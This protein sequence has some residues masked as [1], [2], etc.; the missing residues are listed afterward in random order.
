MWATVPIYISLVLL[1]FMPPVRLPI[2][3]NAPQTFMQSL[4][5]KVFSY[6]ICLSGSEYIHPSLY[7]CIY[8]YLLVSTCK[9]VVLFNSFIFMYLL[10]F[11]ETEYR[12]MIC[13]DII[14]SCTLKF[15]LQNYTQNMQSI[16]FL[17]IYFFQGNTWTLPGTILFV[18][19]TREEI[20]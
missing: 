15:I 5:Q 17:D 4:L 1:G 2:F 13:R 14:A 20:C 16:K 7:I 10:F 19:I 18:R 12:F 3:F 11:D 9:C 6:H 8:I